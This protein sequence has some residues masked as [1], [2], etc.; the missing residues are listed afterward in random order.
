MKK[1][2]LKLL[3]FILILFQA[4]NSYAR[5]K[6]LVFEIDTG[7]NL[8]HS[9]ISSHVHSK[10]VEN[11]THGHGTHIAGIILDGVCKEVEL[12]SCKYYGN[13]DSFLN[14]LRCFQLALEEKVDI[15][16]FSSYGTTASFKEYLVLK[17]LSD[18]NIKIVV[19]AGNDGKDLNI[20]GSYPAKYPLKNI[21]PVGNSNNLTSNYGLKNMVWEDGNKVYSTMPNGKYDTMTG[22]SQAAAKRTNRILKEMCK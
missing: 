15:V 7:L 1:D 19:A 4:T 6:I 3:L 14:A 21:I 16:N 11:D 18:R 12:I 2:L 5:R 13:G 22:S 20:Y 17:Q 9:L 10:N 8:S